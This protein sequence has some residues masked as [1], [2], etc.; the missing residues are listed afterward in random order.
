MGYNEEESKKIISKL[1]SEKVLTL[2]NA[3][4]KY[5]KE[6]G[7]IRYNNYLNLIKNTRKKHKE[8]DTTGY[9]GVMFSKTIDPSTGEFYAGESLKQKI[10][11][12]CK[13]YFDCGRKVHIQNLKNRKSFT[14]YQKE[15]WINKG[16][17]Y[18]DALKEVSLRMCHT[19]IEWFIEHYGIKKGTEK[20]IAR[21]EK[22]KNTMQN[23][24]DE[25]K[26][27][28]ILKRTKISH[29]VSIA[30]TTFFKNIIKKL[31]EQYNIDLYNDSKLYFDNN[32]YYIYDNEYK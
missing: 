20:Y 32:E 30:S 7:T 28:M 5:G 15:Y 31:K 27:E 14:V 25:E 16:Y 3:I 13:K 9:Y 1:Q 2:E 18:I 6:E 22:Y 8:I 11:Q 29:K 19:N 21:I 24:S 26:Y 17:S 4:I 23:K 12:S 10:V